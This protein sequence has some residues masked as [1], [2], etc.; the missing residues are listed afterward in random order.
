MCDLHV[1]YTRLQKP[2]GVVYDVYFV[3]LNR[4]M[5]QNGTPMEHA[6][7]CKIKVSTY[8]INKF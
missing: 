4:K 7:I 1:Q 3:L 8:C 6:L 2:S 5:F